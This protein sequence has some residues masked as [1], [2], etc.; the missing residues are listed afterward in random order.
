MH[1]TNFLLSLHHTF[2]LSL[3]LSL[4]YSLFSNTPPRLLLSPLSMACFIEMCVFMPS[5]LNT[6]YIFIIS[7]YLKL[8]Y[9]GKAFLNKFRY[10]LRKCRSLID[11][12]VALEKSF[13]SLNSYKRVFLK[14]CLQRFYY[15][16]IIQG[17]L[18]E[19]FFCFCILLKLCLNII[20]KYKK[21]PN[22]IF[23]KNK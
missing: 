23:T 13:K 18:K 1:N 7:M 15:P 17:T 12:L 14:C 21:P 9:I 20:I 5:E 8:I 19:N 3:S 4:F 6:F 2:S 22:S 16:V 11:S 10:S